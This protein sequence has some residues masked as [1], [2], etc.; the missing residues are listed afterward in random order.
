MHAPAANHLISEKK[1]SMD[2]KWEWQIQGKCSSAAWQA[3]R[4]SGREKF[5]SPQWERRRKERK[6]NGKES[7]RKGKGEVWID[8]TISAT[9]TPTHTHTHTHAQTWHPLSLLTINMLQTTKQSL[10]VALITSFGWWCQKHLTTSHDISVIFKSGAWKLVFL[11]TLLNLFIC[12]DMVITILEY[13]GITWEEFM[14]LWVHLL[15]YNL[16][17]SCSFCSRHYKVIIQP[18][19][20]EQEAALAGSTI[21]FNIFQKILW[22]KEIFWFLKK[23]VQVLSSLHTMCCNGL[24]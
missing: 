18:S 13:G 14:L 10:P 11:H 9:C 6:Q 2:A 16:I 22:V 15:L 23:K 5:S 4:Q 7:E 1:N 19:D 17:A 8:A 3:G 21:A 20:P 12:V 24:D